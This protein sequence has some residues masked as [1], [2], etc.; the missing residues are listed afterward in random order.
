MVDVEPKKLMVS[1]VV[2][3]DF[4]PTFTEYVTLDRVENQ[5]GIHKVESAEIKSDIRELQKALDS[6]GKE[7]VFVKEGSAYSNNAEIVSKECHQ[8]EYM[9]EVTG[10]LN[11]QG[12]TGRQE[13]LA[14]INYGKQSW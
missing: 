11:G 13:L 12:A 7:G 1:F 3:F 2:S 8:G 14:T 9:L 4:L 10:H 5:K 6:I